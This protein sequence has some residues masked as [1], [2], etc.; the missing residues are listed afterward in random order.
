MPVEL[1]KD[2]V[3]LI[4]F[5][6]PLPAGTAAAAPAALTNTATAIDITPT[7]GRSAFSFTYGAEAIDLLDQGSASYQK[8]QSDEMVT[9]EMGMTCNLLTDS[10]DVDR[11]TALLNRDWAEC[12][13]WYGP[14]GRATGDPLITFVAILQSQYAQNGARMTVPWVA[15]SSSPV[16]I[17]TW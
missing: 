13:L 11:I 14:A 7:M 10:T 2:A 1:V 16:G 8:R 17:I 12:R 4:S 3:V 9:A 6:T 15:R 5:A